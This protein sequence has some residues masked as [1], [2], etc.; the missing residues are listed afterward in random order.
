M[1]RPSDRFFEALT[2]SHTTISYVDV[3]G[4]TLNT[5]RLNVTAGQ[6][7]VDKTASVR[8]RVSLTCI[9]PLGEMTPAIAGDLLTPYGTEIRPYRGIRYP[10][11]TEEVCPLGVF[12]LSKITIKDSVKAM[13]MDIEAYDLSRTVSRD[14]FTSPYT[15]TAGTNVITA[16]KNIL[17]LTVDDIP[18]DT[19]ATNLTV[20]PVRVFDVGEDPWDTCQT[21]AKSIGAD[22]YF[23]IFGGIVIAPPEDIQSLTTEDF[24]YIEGPGCTM[25]EVDKVFDDE[26][27]YNG[28][29]VTGE[30]PGDEKPPVRG[31]AWDTE[32]TSLTYHLGPYGEVP[33]FHQDQL[34][35]TTEDAQ[36]TAE[37]LLA[38]QLGFVSQLTLSTTVNPAYECGDVIRV[39]RAKSKVDDRFLIDAFTVPLTAADP[40]SITLR[41]KRAIS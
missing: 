28:V 31:I 17:D 16:I 20:N 40:Q 27:G 35:K 32:P 11:G 3:T 26:A 29:V 6:V 30:S 14:K 36:N 34:I 38:A 22:L 25:I 13:T 7:S 33:L 9:D 2:L 39:V 23:D 10:D 4:P 12:R 1:Y 5:V 37:A 19:M 41:Q 21:L 8:R 18:Y 24:S 15:I